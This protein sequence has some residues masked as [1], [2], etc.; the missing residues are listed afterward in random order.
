MVRLFA[1]TGFRASSVIRRPRT[2]LLRHQ[3]CANQ[4]CKQ[5]NAATPCN[6]NC[7]LL[8]QKLALNGNTMRR[9]F[10]IDILIRLIKYSIQCKSCYHFNGILKRKESSI[11]RQPSQSARPLAHT[12]RP[13]TGRCFIELCRPP[14]NEVLSRS[15]RFAG[16]SAWRLCKPNYLRILLHTLI[17]SAIF[18]SHWPSGWK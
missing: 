5:Q 2:I 7:F 1:N 11:T 17:I 10:P 15:G 4:R 16:T 18:P 12:C 6:S 9:W 14:A 8:S 13:E 3:N